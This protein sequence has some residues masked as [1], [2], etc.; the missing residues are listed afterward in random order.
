MQY[1]SLLIIIGCHL[2]I[3]FGYETL[4]QLLSFTSFEACGQRMLK[5]K[6]EENVLSC[7]EIEEAV[8]VVVLG[9]LVVGYLT[10]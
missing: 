10:L 1:L 5:T 6:D 2:V 3:R 7:D 4:V 9:V 8:A